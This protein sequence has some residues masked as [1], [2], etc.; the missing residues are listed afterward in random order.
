ALRNLSKL[1]IMP[2]K[3]QKRGFKNLPMFEEPRWGYRDQFVRS[4][5]DEAHKNLCSTL[6]WAW[7]TYC[8]IYHGHE[9]VGVPAP[10]HTNKYSD[11]E[12][13]LD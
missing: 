4:Q 13:G 7:M 3:N 10:F 9:L 6:F 11:A 2:I 12:L 1:S 8:M 5:A